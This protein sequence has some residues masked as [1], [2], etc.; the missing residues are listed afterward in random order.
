MD[1]KK[2][3]TSKNI[4][5]YSKYAIL[6]LLIIIAIAIF[7]LNINSKWWVYIL[8]LEIALVASNVIK[9]FWVKRYNQKIALYVVDSGIMFALAFLTGSSYMATMYIIILSEFYLSSKSIKDN[10]IF[11][12]ISFLIYIISYIG[13]AV[14]RRDIPESTDYITLIITQF[15]ND[16]IIFVLHFAILNMVIRL[17]K[18]N[19]IIA[20]SLEQA[21]ESR[22]KL[23]KAYNELSEVTILKERN[24]IAKDIHDTAG[25]SI[26]TVI[27][28][29]EAAK[30]KIDADVADAKKRI[31]S[32]NLQARNALEE[33]RTC[34]HLLAGDNSKQPLKAKLEAIIEESMNST[35][36]VVRSDI[37]EIMLSDEVARFICNTL[38]EGIS[39]GLRHGEA[40]AFYFEFKE[41][42]GKVK[43][44]L[45]DNGKGANPEKIKE[46]FGITSMKSKAKILGGSASILSAEDDGFEINLTL[47]IKENDD[48]E[49]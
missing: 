9:C 6:V 38:K 47:P 49:D 27:M 41:E 33:L 12:S 34:V 1:L 19:E 25:H 13:V 3:F 43:F 17:I 28:Q 18:Q 2:R 20:E 30:L 42:D 8:L 23:L 5:N 15:F 22:Q 39:N 46:G 4:F 36:I 16:A 29:T 44:L 7:L 14:V 24:R 10:S 26:T 32:A 11:G 40:T 37:Q 48:G 21:K 31:E 45:S 35:D